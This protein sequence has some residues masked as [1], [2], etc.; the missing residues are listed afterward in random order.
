VRVAP[1]NPDDDSGNLAGAGG[2]VK[3]ACVGGGP[4]GLYF[5]L[6]LKLR[7]PQHD[8]TLFERELPG[9]TRG[10]GV[11]FWRDLLEKLYSA[12]PRSACAIEQ[13]SFGGDEALVFFHGVWRVTDQMKALNLKGKPKPK[14]KPRRG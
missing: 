7:A 11:V 14:L 5:T 13:A 1:A 10:W 9:A 8:I 12:D 2:T 4:A 3:I 6:L